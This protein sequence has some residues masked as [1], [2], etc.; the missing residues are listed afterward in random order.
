[1]AQFIGSVQEFHHFIGPRIRNVINTAAAS[2]RRALGGVCQDCGEVAELQSAHVHGHE[3]RVLIEGVLA[4]YTRRDGWIDCDLGEVE[5]RIVEAHMPI[6]ATF[7]FICH[8]CH[9]AYDA[10]TRVPRTRSTGNDGEFPR[11]SRIEL[12]AG[13][14]NQANHQII[15]AF[16][17]LE[18]QG[19]VRLEALRNYC[20]G[21]LGIVGFD[22]KYA[23]MKTDAGNSYGK[24]FFDEDGVVDIW[25]IVRRE[26]QTYF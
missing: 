24:V 8:P 22:G 11:L 12:W 9:V 20:Q 19:P 3:R 4:D 7:K 6:E 2:H 18:N 25:P 10:G 5:R 15:R 16:L 26:V 21:D 17:H 13:R 23:S 14:P 1:L